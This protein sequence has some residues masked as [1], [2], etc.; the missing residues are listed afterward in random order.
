[1]GKRKIQ[2]RINMME[3]QLDP[4]IAQILSDLRDGKLSKK[5][6]ANKNRVDLAVVCRVMKSNN[7]ALSQVKDQRDE[8]ENN[9]PASPSA[10][11]FTDET[12]NED[13]RRGGG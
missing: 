9:N 11:V 3:N 5:E 13:E 1:M 8:D 10:E 6:I 2:S 7:F 12:N 4:K